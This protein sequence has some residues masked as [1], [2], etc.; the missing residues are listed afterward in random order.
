MVYSASCLNTRTVSKHVVPNCFYLE[1]TQAE[2]QLKCIANM[3]YQ[4][5][6]NTAKDLC[7]FSISAQYLGFTHQDKQVQASFLQSDVFISVQKRKHRGRELFIHGDN[8]SLFTIK[9]L[10]TYCRNIA[11][12]SSVLT[13]FLPNSFAVI[14]FLALL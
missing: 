8:L 11:V 4:I 2:F 10:C 3:K 14:F 7:L 13:R 5:F 6:R 9:Y 12:S 1:V